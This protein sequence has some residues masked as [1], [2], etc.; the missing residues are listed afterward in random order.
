MKLLFVRLSLFAHATAYLLNFYTDIN[1]NLSLSLI[2]GA[3]VIC[4]FAIED[5]MSSQDKEK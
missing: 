2:Y 3:V 4:L 5:L 1:F